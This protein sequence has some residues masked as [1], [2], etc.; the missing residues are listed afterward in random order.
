MLGWVETILPW[1]RQKTPYF[2]LTSE[3]CF[4]VRDKGINLKDPGK[5]RSKECSFDLIGKEKRQPGL[6]E[7]TMVM[8]STGETF[9][10]LLFQHLHNTLA[11]SLLGALQPE[12]ENQ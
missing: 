3:D 12:V 11:R 10:E 5:N 8:G 6:E 9:E 4:K 1:T 7:V 2:Y